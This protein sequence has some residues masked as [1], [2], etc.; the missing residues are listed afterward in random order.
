MFE[1][2]RN[3]FHSI[4]NIWQYYLHLHPNGKTNTLNEKNNSM[5]KTVF[6]LLTGALLYSCTPQEVPVLSFI[7]DRDGTEYTMVKIGKQI[8]M[9]ENLAYLDE[10][11]SSPTIGSETEPHYY[12]YDYNDTEV[13]DAKATNNYKT[14]GVLYNFS[15]ALTACP[16]GWRLPSDDDW[17]QFE[18]YLKDNVGG[19]LKAKTY[20]N[21]PNTGAT[22]KSGF[23]ALPGGD[24]ITGGA[25]FSIGYYGYWWS[26]SGYNTSNAWYRCLSYDY[27]SVI[28]DSDNK[29]YG[30]SIRCVRD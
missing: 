1:G 22:N 17:T 18:E 10:T 14:Y 15:A 7:D 28:R 23:S 8:W 3:S 30:F 13:A 9:A 26:S 21:D 27:S 6:T 29:A 19:K 24:R 20:W 11:I 12:V 4:Q 5:K 16:K 2:L 25:F